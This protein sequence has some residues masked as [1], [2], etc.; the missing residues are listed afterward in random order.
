MREHV[1]HVGIH[2]FRHG[3]I[4][5]L[6]L[7][8]VPAVLEDLVEQLRGLELR[9]ELVGHGLNGRLIHIHDPL[10]RDDLERHIRLARDRTVG[11]DVVDHAPCLHLLDVE[12]GEAHHLA[13]IMPGIHNLRLDR[14][15]RATNVGGHRQF[16]NLKSEIVQTSNT[17]VHPPALAR[18]EGLLPGQLIPQFLVALEES[19]ADGD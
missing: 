3:Y 8:H 4:A 12:A 5:A 10:V 15:R 16:A 19:V 7:A 1:G 17:R 13:R 18:L 14:D 2:D 11:L 9:A 6:L